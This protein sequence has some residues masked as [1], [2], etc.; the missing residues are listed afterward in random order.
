MC[1]RRA[2]PNK[3]KAMLRL[4]RTEEL[5]TA[6]DVVTACEDSDEWNVRD[7]KLEIADSFEKRKGDLKAPIVSP[8]TL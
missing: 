1:N 7:M 8:F 6:A 4:M 5:L 2:R 3:A